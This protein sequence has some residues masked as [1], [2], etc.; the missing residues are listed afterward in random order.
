MNFEIGDI[1]EV[2]GNSYIGKDGGRAK[3]VGFTDNNELK[4]VWLDMPNDVSIHYFYSHFFVINKLYCRYIKN[5]NF[6][7]GDKVKIKNKSVGESFSTWKA[8]CNSFIS[9]VTAI[10]GNGSGS[11]ENN[12]IVIDGNF[13]APIDLELINENK[14]MNI[15]EKF[16]LA[17]TKEPQKSFRKVGITNGDDI[18]TD[19]GQAVFLSWLLHTK[20]AEEF[21]AEVADDMLKELEKEK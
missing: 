12:C 14:N 21:K 5:M 15:K 3:V 18:L 8:R 6:K 19:E 20:F 16:V 7:V 9:E 13:F 10:Y 1:I 11:N 2:K 4:I 17:L